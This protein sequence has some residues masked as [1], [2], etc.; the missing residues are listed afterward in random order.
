[1]SELKFKVNSEPVKI[2]LKNFSAK[3][4]PEPLLNIAGAVMRSSIER[5]FR[6]QGSPDGS[7]APL[8]A[9]T[10]KRGKGGA[11]RMILIQSG[12]LKNSVNYQVN[13]N[14]MTIGTNLRYAAIQHAGGVAGRRGPFK[15]KGGRRPMIPA[16][17]FIVFR[18]EDPQRIADAMQRYIDQAAQQTGLK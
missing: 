13:G 4:A 2:A 6:G 10:L 7:W 3:L 17:P 5:T 15:K 11:G 1:M 9:S 8:A 18:P 12:R 14:T 16:R